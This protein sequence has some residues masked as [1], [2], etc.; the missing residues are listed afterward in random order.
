MAKSALFLL[1]TFIITSCSKNDKTIKPGP[2]NQESIRTESINDITVSSYGFLIFPQAS[3]VDEFLA[4]II[5]DTHGDVQ[6]YLGRIGFSSQGA[7]LYGSTYTNQAVTNGEAAYYLLSSAGI[8]QV[9]DIIYR[10]IT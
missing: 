2:D 8:V 10:P 5:G 9:E 4:D 6:A 3:D 1:F 7:S